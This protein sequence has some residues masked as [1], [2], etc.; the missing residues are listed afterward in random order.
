[1]SF[2]LMVHLPSL[3]RAKVKVFDT[4][5]SVRLDSYGHGLQCIQRSLCKPWARKTVTVPAQM[6]WHV[7]TST[8]IDVNVILSNIKETIWKKQFNS[9][10]SGHLNWQWNIPIYSR[11]SNDFPLSDQFYQ[12]LILIRSCEEGPA[13]SSPVRLQRWFA[14]IRSWSSHVI[15]QPFV[16]MGWTTQILAQLFGSCLNI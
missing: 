7:L 13:A 9:M 15:S 4:P 1:M 16:S 8:S 3:A 10:H 12:R 5:S 2:W 6:H 14:C 11:C